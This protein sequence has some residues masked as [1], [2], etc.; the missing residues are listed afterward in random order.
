MG[1]RVVILLSVVA[2]FLSE[3]SLWKQNRAARPQGYARQVSQATTYAAKTMRWSGV[4]VL[5]FI[6]Y[7]LLHLTLGA[8]VAGYGITH[9]KVY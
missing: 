7:H 9:G 3:F 6:V 2:H 5:L 4:I 1:A 8:S